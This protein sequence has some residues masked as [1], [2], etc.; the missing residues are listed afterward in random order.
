MKQNE[1]P[2]HNQDNRKKASDIIG[3]PDDAA[4]IT[5]SLDPYF[6]Q[7]SAVYEAHKDAFIALT[8]EEKA[9]SFVRGLK[10]KDLQQVFDEEKAA[11]IWKLIY[12]ATQ[13]PARKANQ[14]PKSKKET[15]NLIFEALSEISASTAD[16]IKLYELKHPDGIRV[17]SAFP[18]KYI[19]P[20]DKVTKKTF[21][22]MTLY[23]KDYIRVDIGPSQKEI[24]SYVRLDIENNTDIQFL[25]ENKLTPYDN[26]VHNAVVTLYV[27]G[28]NEYVTPQMI[29]RTMT[30]N[31][32]AQITKNTQKEI[33]ESLQKLART[34]I[35]IKPSP[36]EAKAY[37]FDRVEFTYRGSI[38]MWEAAVDVII[39]RQKCENVYHIMRTPILYTYAAIKKQIATI[40]I[41]LLNTPVY[42]RKTVMQLQSY[43]LKR[44]LAMKNGKVSH[45]ILYSSIYEMAD[46]DDVKNIKKRRADIRRTVREILQYWKDEKFIKGF[47]EKFEG[48]QPTKIT[49]SL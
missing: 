34:W 14:P 20:V 7:V 15:E 45:T 31:P 35:D 5:S 3:P 39:N 48:Q 4:I 29:Y 40:D 1:K 38:I 11:R 2:D 18:E 17:E 36:E 10:P 26:D 25:D 24:L 37:K 23:N 8:N 22:D 47:S 43:L 9:V 19:M 6:E 12:E 46:F 28:N 21:T 16:F 49:I 44:I 42:K 41:K 27:N 30:G 13:D 33:E 32:T